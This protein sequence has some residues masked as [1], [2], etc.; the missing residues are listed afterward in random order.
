MGISLGHRGDDDAQWSFYWRSSSRTKYMSVMSTTVLGHGISSA[1]FEQPYVQI[2]PV[3]SIFLKLWTNFLLHI[4]W[5]HKLYT[6]EFFL[7]H[8]SL[9]HGK[10]VFL[11]FYVYFVPF[12]LT[13]WHAISNP[14]KNKKVHLC[15]VLTEL[16]R[17]SQFLAHATGRQITWDCLLNAR[18]VACAY[19][20]FMI[21]L[22]SNFIHFEFQP[23]MNLIHC[24]NLYF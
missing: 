3:R 11:I 5:R 23:T 14:A 19:F 10:W 17:G 9:S 4:F 13:L 6:V 7:G 8:F 21:T 24:V 16:W 12:S 2:W 20:I 18:P 22:L 1:I 15:D